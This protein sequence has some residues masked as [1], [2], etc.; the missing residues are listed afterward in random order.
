MHSVLISVAWLLLAMICSLDMS[1][2]TGTVTVIIWTLNLTITL[3]LNLSLTLTV[4][5][6]PYTSWSIH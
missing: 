2:V 5:I 1:E 6:L 4:Q 3:I